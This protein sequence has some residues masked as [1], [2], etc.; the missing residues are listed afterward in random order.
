MGA[1]AATQTHPAQAPTQRKARSPRLNFVRIVH[2]EWIKL[3]SLRSTLVLLPVTFAGMVGIGLLNA[4]AIGYMA[5][6]SNMG[7]GQTQPMALDVPASGIMIGQLLFASLAV[8]HIGSE[9]GTGMISTTMT[10]APRRSHVLLA[11]VLVMSVVAFVVGSTAALASA[12]LSQPLLAGFDAD[13]PL[14]TDGIVASILN[15]GTFLALISILALGVGALVRNSAG[16][17]VTTLGML[18]VLPITAAI[19]SGTEIVQTMSEFLPSNAGTQLVSVETA[20][21]SL[22]QL[23]GGLVLAAW[24]GAALIPALALLERRDV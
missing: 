2:S 19:F 4:W 9:Y 21:E 11:K 1:H 13:F 6:E 10:A 3:I 20:K 18:M 12:V 7:L 24:A 15:T 17:I 8:V 23:Q 14:S 5:A 16:G 22:T